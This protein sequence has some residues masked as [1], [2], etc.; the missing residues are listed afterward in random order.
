[1]GEDEGK[2]G[3]IDEWVRPLRMLRSEGRCKAELERCEGMKEKADALARWNVRRGVEV[4]AG[5]ESVKR[6]VQEREL[7]VHGLM[8]DLGTGELSVCDEEGEGLRE[9]MGEVAETGQPAE[10]KE[11][12]GE[13][14]KGD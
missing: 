4:L 6:A 5:M 2:L 14:G 7:H 10:G 1:M 11:K 8:Y 13:S 3:V 12:E 9:V